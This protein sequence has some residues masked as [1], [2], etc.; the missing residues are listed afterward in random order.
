MKKIA[1]NHW[2][3][4][5]NELS[6]SL[7]RYFV[8]INICLNNEFIFYRLEVFKENRIILVFKFYTLSDAIQFTEEIIKESIETSEIVEQYNNRFKNGKYTQTRCIRKKNQRDQI[9]R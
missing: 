8:K 9:K 7:M 2:L 1:L 3:V 4:V 6:I 5:D